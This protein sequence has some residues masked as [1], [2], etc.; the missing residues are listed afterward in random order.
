VRTKLRVAAER[1]RQSVAVIRAI[2][3]DDEDDA[4]SDAPKDVLRPEDDA[5]SEHRQDPAER[6]AGPPNHHDD[7]DDPAERDAHAHAAE[8]S[9]YVRSS[10]DLTDSD[11]RAEREA[12]SI[13]IDS[14]IFHTSPAANEEAQHQRSREGERRRDAFH[15][16]H[17]A[18]SP[19]G[20][21]PGSG[22]T[23]PS[24]SFLGWSRTSFIS[25]PFWTP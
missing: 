22:H 12:P 11:R 19:M 20:G 17:T 18:P 1:V 25:S 24:T 10:T 9:A 7:K 15:A 4:V 16:A 14:S 13:H 21:F 5:L 3:P 2:R 6:E 8:E 23:V